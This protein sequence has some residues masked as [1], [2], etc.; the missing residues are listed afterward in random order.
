MILQ[1]LTAVEIGCGTHAAAFFSASWRTSIWPVTAAEINAV[2]R[3]CKQV[4]GALSLG[5]EGV[6]LYR[7][8]VNLIDDCVLLGEGGIRNAQIPNLS[9]GNRTLRR[10]DFFAITP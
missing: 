1:P 8:D 7:L 9:T 3:S 5:S 10:T 6:E 4:D 2:R